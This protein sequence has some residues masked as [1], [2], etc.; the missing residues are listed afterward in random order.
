[1]HRLIGG[2]FLHHP[3]QCPVTVEPKRRSPLTKGV[4]PFT[5]QDEHYFA[6]LDDARA[7]VFLHSRSE[8]GVQPA[9]WTRI[10]GKGRVCVLTPGHNLKV[11]L[12]PMFQTL[13][14]NAMCWA[15]KIK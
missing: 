14:L 3:P 1:M 4:M 8:H 15:A 11:W 2:T 6:K 9:G 7:K 13:L 5:V 10:E 12:H